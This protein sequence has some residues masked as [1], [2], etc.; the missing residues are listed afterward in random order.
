MH[1]PVPTYVDSELVHDAPGATGRDGGRADQVR[2]STAPRGGWRTASV[3][4]SA[5]A[6]GTPTPENFEE[7]AGWALAATPDGSFEY[8]GGPIESPH[9]R[10]GL[11]YVD[12]VALARGDYR[13]Y[14]EAA[15]PDGAHEL[16]TEVVSG[17]V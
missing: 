1:V 14:Y 8:A 3:A 4:R 13:L 10:H 7:R 5:R 15:R 17:T 11:R 2:C 16:R 12:A 6:A 9:A